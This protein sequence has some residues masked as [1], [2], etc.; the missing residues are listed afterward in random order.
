[1]VKKS[2]SGTHQKIKGR[3]QGPIKTAPPVLATRPRRARASARARAAR[4]TMSP[5][6]LL[7]VVPSPRCECVSEM[8]N[9]DIPSP[10]CPP[11]ARTGTNTF[12]IEGSRQRGAKQSAEL[13]ARE[14]RTKR[15][16]GR[17]GVQ[18][19]ASGMRYALCA[20]QR[21][22][23]MRVGDKE[24][25]RRRRRKRSAGLRRFAER[26]RREARA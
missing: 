12:S 19:R 9:T 11:R 1:M 5:P 21:R 15:T 13:R 18:V 6:C 23:P 25:A 2:G 26:A 14:R 17:L 24:E 8:R 3:G 4:A 20:I 16:L 10:I 7:S 22:V